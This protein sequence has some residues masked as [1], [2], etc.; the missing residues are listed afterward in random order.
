VNEDLSALSECKKLKELQVSRNPNL[1]S[2]RGL[3]LDSIE[4]IDATHC[5]LLGDHSFLAE[6]P[7]LKLLDI[8]GSSNLE[9]DES[10]FAPGVQILRS[11]F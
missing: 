9:I 1:R 5:Y 11:A 7:N 8:R 6:A 10:K 4:R 3:A 2:L